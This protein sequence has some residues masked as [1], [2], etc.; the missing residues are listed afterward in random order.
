MRRVLAQ[1]LSVA[2]ADASRPVDSHD[3]LVE[4]TYFDYDAGTVP[5]RGIRAQQVLHPHAVVD[6]PEYR[7][8]S[9]IKVHKDTVVFI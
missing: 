6:L 5:L 4:L 1:V 3:V 7:H 2:E 8:E 9:R